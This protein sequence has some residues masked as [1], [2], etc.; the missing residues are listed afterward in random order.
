MV[1]IITQYV[2]IVLL[3]MGLGYLAYL[4]KEKGVNIK[5]D[6]FGLAYIILDSLTA[7]ESTPEN[8]KKIIRIVSK[9]VQYVETN[10][11]NSKNTLKEEEALKIV[12][13]GINLLNFHSDV[14]DESVKYLIR[15]AAALLPPTN[16]K[17]D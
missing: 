13:E 7:E 6:Y 4:L 17:I 12:K 10:Y 2:L 3:V 14:D 5:D 16:K 1:E 8:A 15:L 9:A 11:K